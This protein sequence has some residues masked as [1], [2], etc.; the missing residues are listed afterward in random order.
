[1]FPERVHVP[2]QPRQLELNDL[3]ENS[4]ATWIGYGGSRGGAKSHGARAVMLRRR[5]QYAGTAG[6]IIRRTYDDLWEEHITKYF[7][8]WPFLRELYNDK[9]R[10]IKLPNGSAIKFGYALHPGDVED[11]FQGKG[12]MDIF[13]D[14]ATKYSERDL[15]FLRTSCRWPGVPENAC[16]FVLTMN[17]GGVSHSFVKRIFLSGPKD[18]SLYREGEN[19]NDYAFIQSRAWDNVEWVRASLEADGLSTYDF[20]KWSEGERFEYFVSRSDYGKKLNALPAALRV[21]HLLGDWDR[22]AGQYFDIFSEQRFAKDLRSEI[23]PWYPRWLSLDWGYA[24]NSA[25][26]G[27]VT[28]PNEHVHTYRELVVNNKT[29]RDLAEAIYDAF[30]GDKLQAIYISPDMN[31]RREGPETVAM[32]LS[33][34]LEAKGM[35]RCTLANNKRVAGWM[36]WYQ[37]MQTDMWSCDPS[38]RVLIDTLPNASRGDVDDGKAEDIVKVNVDGAS[39]SYGDDSWDSVRMGLLSRLEPG[40]PPLAVRVEERVKN[41]DYTSR[42]HFIPRIL[43]EEQRRTTMLPFTMK[44]GRR[45]N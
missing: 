19:P 15:T 7:R 2:L 26:Y 21:G 42:Q 44:S 38:C 37:L 13:V 20:Y 8:D 18:H 5:L 25:A 3:V 36:L 33:D 12:F 22:Y 24:H 28:M 45:A 32:Q 1:M 39:G 10:E 23:R 30:G 27:H 29:P 17:P 4:E 34:Y 6:V 41:L 11:Q 35:P 16:K 9:H 40:Q 43:R 14:E 31:A